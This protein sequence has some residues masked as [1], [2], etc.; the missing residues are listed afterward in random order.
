MIIYTV[1]V[2]MSTVQSAFYIF[3]LDLFYFL[4]FMIIFYRC[5]LFHIDLSKSSCS[6]LIINVALGMIIIMITITTKTIIIMIII[7]Y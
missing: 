7:M 5:L 3:F 6:N 2:V 1:L 4:L